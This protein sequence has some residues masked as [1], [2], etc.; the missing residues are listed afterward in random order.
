MLKVCQILEKMV[1]ILKI[2]YY[3]KRDKHRKKI[4]Y[5]CSVEKC[6]LIP[7]IE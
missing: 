7:H 6:G 1:K 2:E 5:G 3:I 4:K